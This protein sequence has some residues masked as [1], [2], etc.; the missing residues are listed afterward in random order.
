M[1]GIKWN[2]SGKTVGKPI[3]VKPFPVKGKKSVKFPT[4]CKAAH[5]PVESLIMPL[6]NGSQFRYH[7]MM[8][9]R[10][11]PTLELQRHI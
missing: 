2:D 3:D 11:M 10:K 8:T 4:N 6:H 5:P 1:L 9:T 7:M